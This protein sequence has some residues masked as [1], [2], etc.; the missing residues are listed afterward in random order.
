MV[1][2]KYGFV[3]CGKTPSSTHD[4]LIIFEDVDKPVSSD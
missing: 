1:Q 2:D 4:L 3:F